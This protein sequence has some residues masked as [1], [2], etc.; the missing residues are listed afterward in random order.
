MPPIRP[1]PCPTDEPGD[2]TDPETILLPPPIPDCPFPLPPA[3]DE[4][5]MPM[6]RELVLDDPD[7]GKLPL[8]VR[9]GN[10]EKA[11]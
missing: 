5:G 4:E 11:F 7:P 10:I 9:D 1:G 2:P 8:P 6:P 3:I